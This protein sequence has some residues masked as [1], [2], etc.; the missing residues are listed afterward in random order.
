ML[1]WAS[2]CAPALIFPGSISATTE[3][4][5]LSG[6]HSCSPLSPVCSL[7]SFLLSLLCHN[8]ILLP[9]LCCGLLAGLEISSLA[10]SEV[11]NP[12][13]RVIFAK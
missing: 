13:A 1:P 4:S 9:E 11:Y 12:G 2:L 8:P 5:V 7:A 10:S 6:L 3:H